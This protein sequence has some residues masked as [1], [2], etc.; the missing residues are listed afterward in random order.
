MCVDSTQGLSQV[1]G[2]YGRRI[3]CVWILWK[4][5]HRLWILVYS[6]NGKLLALKQHNLYSPTQ[7][8]RQRNIVNNRHVSSSRGTI[9][10][11]N[12]CETHIPDSSQILQLEYLGN[13]IGAANFVCCEFERVAAPI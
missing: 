9:P 13:V 11:D 2:F 7:Q 10:F 12:F 4:A 8:K 3:T 5:L 6:G 1:Y